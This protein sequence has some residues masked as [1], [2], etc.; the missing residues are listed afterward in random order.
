MM[1]DNAHTIL[2]RMLIID[3]VYLVAYCP[4]YHTILHACILFIC[5]GVKIDLMQI[6]IDMFV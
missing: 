2:D 5:S 1:T 6:I 3:I 4:P